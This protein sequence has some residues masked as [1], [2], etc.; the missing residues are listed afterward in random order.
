MNAG[1]GGG[2]NWKYD[3]GIQAIALRRL[4]IPRDALSSDLESSFSLVWRSS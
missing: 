1:A 2:A 3:D 4:D